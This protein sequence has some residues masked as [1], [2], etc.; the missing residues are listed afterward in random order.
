MTPKP[1][2]LG[3]ASERR[4]SILR[5]LGVLFEVLVPETPEVLEGAP[6]DIASRNAAAKNEWCARHR[7]D[8]FILTA[9]TVVCL[10]GRSY[11]KP[12]DAAE[13]EQFLRTFSGRTHSVLTAVVLAPPRV[14]R[15]PP[16]SHIVE[17]SVTFR[18][19]DDPLIRRYVSE[20]MPLDRAG[21]YDINEK[22]DMI[23][24]RYTGSYTN[25]MGLPAET[26]LRWFKEEKLL[27]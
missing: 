25:I 8:H 27:P 13:A 1:L 26:V 21:A 9:D 5:G 18:H 7:P 20:V 24:E 23:I 14:S 11:G 10:E 4:R 16:R 3:S 12:A 15:R 17:S 6:A 19:L 2:I 22:G